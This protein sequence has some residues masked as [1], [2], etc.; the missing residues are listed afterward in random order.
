MT[1]TA[2]SYDLETLKQ[3]RNIKPEWEEIGIEQDMNA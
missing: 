1:D 2:K 3:T